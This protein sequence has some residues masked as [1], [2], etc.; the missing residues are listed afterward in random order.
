M[1]RADLE[2]VEDLEA[3]AKVLRN[4]HRSGGFTFETTLKS[5]FGARIPFEV[6]TRV[7][8]MRGDEVLLSIARDITDRKQ[9]QAAREK[10]IGE[11]KE[12]LAHVKSLKG[13]LPICSWCK[14]IRDDKGYWLE[15]E[16]YLHDH[17]EM[18]FSH[19]ICPECMEQYKKT[20]LERKAR[21]GA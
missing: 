5:K 7:F 3:V 11:L 19:G 12:A 17:S 15:V 20:Y 9:A 2:P 18:D 13:L 16:A 6:N 8:T 14:R 4:R 1:S 21:R 10:L